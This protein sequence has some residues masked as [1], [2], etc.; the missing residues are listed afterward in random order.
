METRHSWMRKLMHVTSKLYQ[1]KFGADI[2]IKYGLKLINHVQVDQ[3]YT[4]MWEDVRIIDK[5]PTELRGVNDGNA[6]GTNIICICDWPI[7]MLVVKP[8]Q[9][10]YF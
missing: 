1:P 7:Y 6:I 9:Q 2:N 8:M 4:D 3:V 5:T 10:H